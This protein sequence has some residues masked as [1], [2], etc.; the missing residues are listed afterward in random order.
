[1]KITLYRKS[2]CPWSAA[3]MGFLNE[4]NIPYEIR[5]VTTNPAYAKEV[6]AATGQSKSPTL[7]I[8]GTILRDA[9]VEEVAQVLEQRGIVI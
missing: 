1:M 5:N 8:D 3:V 2:G 4:M 7:D 9:G 6:E